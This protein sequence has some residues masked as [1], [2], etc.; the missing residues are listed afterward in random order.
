MAHVSVAGPRPFCAVSSAP[1]DCAQARFQT[2]LQ[3]DALVGTRLMLAHTQPQRWPIECARLYSQRTVQSHGH[4][5]LM[6]PE[7]DVK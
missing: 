2:H 3:H 5:G 4:A 7:A 1:K 6:R